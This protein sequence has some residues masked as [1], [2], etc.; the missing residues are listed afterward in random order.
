M[1][2]HT[3]IDETKAGG[4]LVVAA[5]AAPEQLK[6]ASRELA[7]L[8]LPGQRSLHMKSEGASRRRLIADA[9]VGMGADLGVEAVIYDA[10]RV[11][12]ERDRRARC[13]QT[14]VRDAGTRPTTSRLVFDLDQSLQSWDRQQLIELT[15]AAGLRGRVEYT[16]MARHA[17]RLLA[18]P[19]VV[20]WCWAR[21]GDWRQR[22]RPVVVDVCKV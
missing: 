19:D 16:H 14:L 6:I 5:T 10:G 3:Y 18:I 12:P 9:I 2:V 17:D 8:L 21:G 15:R 13:L 11:G 22:V 7:T 20:A 1:T 4:Y